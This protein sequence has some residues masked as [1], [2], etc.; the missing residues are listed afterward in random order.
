MKEVKNMIDQLGGRKFIL[1]VVGI[2][3]LFALV[4]MKIIDA[5]EFVLF[6]TAQIA[7]YQITN[8]VSNFK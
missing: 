5:K 4:I 1:S 8:A 6:L 3:T 7:T 2:V